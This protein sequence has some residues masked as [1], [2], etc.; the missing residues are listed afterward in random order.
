MEVNEGDVSQKLY[1]E[2]NTLKDWAEGK[3]LFSRFNIK[4]HEH[5]DIQALA[6]VEGGG[7]N[8]INTVSMLM[9][10]GEG[11]HFILSLPIQAIDVL[12]TVACNVEE[13]FKMDIPK[14]EQEKN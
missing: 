4:S 9:I 5:L 12:A 11:K 1:V 2:I 6:V 13:S 14:T 3:K 10:S 7:T 8:G